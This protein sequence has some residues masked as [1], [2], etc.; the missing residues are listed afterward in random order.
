MGVSG[1]VEIILPLVDL[2]VDGG[3]VEESLPM[4]AILPWF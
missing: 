4:V 1:E 3:G 2:V